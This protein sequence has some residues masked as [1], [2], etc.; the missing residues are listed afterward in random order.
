MDGFT[1]FSEGD[2]TGSAR[3]LAA[4]VEPAVMLGGS[5]PQRSV[6]RQTFVLACQKAGLDPLGVV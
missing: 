2:Y 3:V 6:V 4:V 5:N 1:A